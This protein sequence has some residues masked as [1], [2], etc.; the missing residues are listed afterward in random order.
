[1]ESS[2]SIADLLKSFAPWASPALV[3][4]LAWLGKRQIKR[5]DKI[6]NECIRKEQFDDSL[7]SLRAAYKEGKDDITTSINRLSDEIRNTNGRIDQAM[8]NSIIGKKGTN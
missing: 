2:G 8:Q 7:N 6:E 5:F 4:I 3:A 1:M